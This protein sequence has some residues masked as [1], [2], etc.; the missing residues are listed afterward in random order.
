MLLNNIT[1][2]LVVTASDI[3][4]LLVPYTSGG[5]VTEL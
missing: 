4:T 1:K 2:P 3:K 5:S